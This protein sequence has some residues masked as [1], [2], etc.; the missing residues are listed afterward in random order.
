[1]KNWPSY[2]TERAAKKPLECKPLDI[3]T[4]LREIETLE[5][6]HNPAKGCLGDFKSVAHGEEV[7][8]LVVFLR[9]LEQAF[10]NEQIVREARRSATVEVVD[11]ES[12]VKTRAFYIHLHEQDFRD[13]VERAA[14][15]HFMYVTQDR[16]ALEQEILELPPV[17]GAEL[18]SDL[19]DSLGVAPIRRLRDLV[20]RHRLARH[21]RDE[22]EHGCVA[23]VV[24]DEE[25]AADR[26]GIALS[27]II[28]LDIDID[29]LGLAFD[30]ENR[31][32]VPGLGLRCFPDH[33]VGARTP[34]S[35]H[36]PPL[37]IH[38]LEGVT[39]VVMQVQNEILPD[40]FFRPARHISPFVAKGNPE[41][42]TWPFRSFGGR[43]ESCL[44]HGRGFPS[45][46]L[47][48]CHFPSHLNFLVNYPEHG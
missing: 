48:H 7:V 42:V 34:V 45:G 13:R 16:M 31:R 38:L 39:V 43:R 10:V 14:G 25:L 1:M 33:D 26:T 9:R 36:G 8:G 23:G 5:F 12:A 3:V 11:R 40:R 6:L 4:G 15:I 44:R 18:V 17:E 19:I 37:L 22:L 24:S 29:F 46:F 20:D 47:R 35:V 21:S 30:H 2:A 28:V 27:L 41:P 32:H